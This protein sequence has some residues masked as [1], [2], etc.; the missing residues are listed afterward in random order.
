MSVFSCLNYLSFPTGV[1]CC[2]TGGFAFLVFIPGKPSN[3]VQPCYSNVYAFFCVCVCVWPATKGNA[4]P[5][6]PV[7][8]TD[9]QAECLHIQPSFPFDPITSPLFGSVLV[10]TVLLVQPKVKDN[11]LWSSSWDG[12]CFCSKHLTPTPRQ[13]FGS[14]AYFKACV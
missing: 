9:G 10:L 2:I 13:N 4:S 1:A 6:Q 12:I 11:C 14:G 8:L 5:M 3:L 7:G